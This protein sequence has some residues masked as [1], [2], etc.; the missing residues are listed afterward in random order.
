MLFQSAGSSVEKRLGV[1][2]EVQALSDAPAQVTLKPVDPQTQQ[3]Q[4]EHSL[5]A[6]RRRV[7]MLH[8]DIIKDLLTYGC[9]QQG[10][11]DNRNCWTS[12]HV[13][14]KVVM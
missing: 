1:V 10:W 4:L 14:I 13:E 7:R 3:E 5:A 6:E 11:Y 12:K 2:Q 8:D 9:I